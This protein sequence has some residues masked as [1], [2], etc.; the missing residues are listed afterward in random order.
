MLA[1]NV[2]NRP[3]FAA[4]NL[5]IVNLSKLIQTR[6]GPGDNAPT[7]SIVGLLKST[8]HPPCDCNDPLLEAA[9]YGVYSMLAG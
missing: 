4:Q 7:L 3:S 5:G 9:P 1:D 6:P 2:E 8:M